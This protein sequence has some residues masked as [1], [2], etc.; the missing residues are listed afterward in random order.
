MAAVSFYDITPIA[1]DNSANVI[2]RLLNTLDIRHVRAA[3]AGDIASFPTAVTC[4]VFSEQ[5]GNQS[6]RL[7][8]M[9]T[10]SSYATLKTALQA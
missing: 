6:G 9:L 3:T 4:I 10:A 5:A 7:R 1:I 2:P 8:N